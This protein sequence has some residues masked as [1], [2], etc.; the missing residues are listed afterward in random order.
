MIRFAGLEFKGLTKET[1]L[2]EEAFIKIIVTVNAEI[3]VLA[4]EHDR[5]RKIINSNYAT[6]DGQIPYL[7]ARLKYRDCYFEKISG[8]DLIYDACKYAKLHRQK[9]FLLG[10]YKETNGLSVERLKK[11]YGIEIEGFSPV[12][13]PYPFDS[14]HNRA[15]LKKITKF[16]PDIL[17]VGFGAK[18]QE[19]WIDDNKMYLNDIG[20]RLAVGCG[21]TFEMV[22][23]QLK[24][25]PQFIQRIGLEGLYRTLKE[26]NLFRLRKLLL[27]FKMFKHLP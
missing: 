4:H 25:A 26:P 12:Y 15:I 21:G 14:E 24:K 3:I 16:C 8:S 7:L 9:I 13:R 2:R 18:K 20:V 1:L 19:F 5:L 11:E 17:F 6:F 22:A 23:G 10:G 27:S